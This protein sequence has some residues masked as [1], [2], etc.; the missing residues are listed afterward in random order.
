MD[1]RNFQSHSGEKVRL[2]PS[3]RSVLTEYVV[4]LAKGDLRLVLDNNKNREL[5]HPDKEE[6]WRDIKQWVTEIQPAPSLV[7]VVQLTYSKCWWCS[8]HPLR[9]R[10]RTEVV[11]PP[12]AIARGLVRHK[13]TKNRN[14]KQLHANRLMRKHGHEPRTKQQKTHR[15]TSRKKRRRRFLWKQALLLKKW[16][17]TS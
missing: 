17:R 11:R 6:G 8:W 3:C 1:A 16:V 14:L 7:L 4:Q 2:A 5:Q 10:G 13:L 9:L 12:S 15:C